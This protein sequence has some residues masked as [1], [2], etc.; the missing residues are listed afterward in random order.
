MEEWGKI[1]E[2]DATLP[3]PLLSGNLLVG[4]GRQG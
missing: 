4:N 2:L 1:E 3:M